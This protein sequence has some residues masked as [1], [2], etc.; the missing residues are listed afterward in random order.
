MQNK[1]FLAIWC[2]IASEHLADYR[3]WIVKEHIADR[4]FSPGFLAARFCIDVTNPNSHFFLYATQSKDV[5]KNPPYL[6]ILNTPS[7]WTRKIM[8][9][10]GAF[11][12]ALGEQVLKIG[13]GIGPY[14]LISR[15]KGPLEINLPLAQLEL[16]A[17]LQLNEIVSVRL[18]VLDQSTIGIKSEEKKM[19]QGIE[20]NFNYLI[21]VEAMSQQAA[22]QAKD[23]LPSV[24]KKVFSKPLS[25]DLSIRK[26]VYSEAP[27]EGPTV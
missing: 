19:R 13:N 8:P 21:V 26:M 11:D 6:Q 2:D 25:F 24:L 27:F 23:L 18:M 14:L 1:G 15:L 7:P 3:E 5:F 16:S 12:R 22:E 20:G 4:I 9:L 17:I 10:F